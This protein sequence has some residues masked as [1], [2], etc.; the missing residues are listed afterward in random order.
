MNSP[1]WGTFGGAEGG[2]G[3]GSRP[4][5]SLMFYVLQ[6]CK[7]NSENEETPTISPP[8]LSD[9]HLP[10][11]SRPDGYGNSHTL[12]LNS[13]I[14]LLHQKN[15]HKLL[16]SVVLNYEPVAYTIMFNVLT[17]I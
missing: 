4:P 6:L 13:V 5:N 10:S 7:R 12:Q 17:P 3:G 1:V 14:A 9:C 8:L 11:F 15:A 16:L 2:F